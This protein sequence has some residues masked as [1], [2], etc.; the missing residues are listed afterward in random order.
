MTVVP[1][2]IGA[3]PNAIYSLKPDELPAFTQALARLAS[4]SDYRAFADR[5]AVRRT[6]GDF[7]AAS[8]KL[9]DAYQAWAPLEAGLF[10]YGR[11]EN[12]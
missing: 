4:E 1:G 10:D 8:D 6:A 2:F 7:W 3:Y 11:F 12:R 5:F 9:H